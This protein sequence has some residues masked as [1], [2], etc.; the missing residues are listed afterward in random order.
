MVVGT[1]AAE[2]PGSIRHQMPVDEA[3][4]EGPCPTLVAFPAASP[5]ANELNLAAELR[6]PGRDRG[7]VSNIFMLTGNMV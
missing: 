5:T 4:I 3:V 1:A 7:A 6:V 2:C